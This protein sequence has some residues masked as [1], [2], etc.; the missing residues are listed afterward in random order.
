MEHCEDVNLLAVDTLQGKQFLIAGQTVV[1]SV[2]LHKA[3]GANSLLAESA[4]ETILM[5]TVP[6]MLHL[7]GAW[8][9]NI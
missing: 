3:L 9:E 1:V 8:N 6:L 2:L 5:P 4:D 7:L